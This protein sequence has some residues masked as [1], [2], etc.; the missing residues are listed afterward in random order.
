MNCFIFFD[1]CPR[2]RRI[3]IVIGTAES[4]LRKFLSGG[5]EIICSDTIKPAVRQVLCFWPRQSDVSTTAETARRGRENSV[6]T[7][8]EL[9][10]TT[11]CSD[12]SETN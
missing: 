7:A 6:A 2:R 5:E 10:V 9:F 1:T 8:S 12:I 11:K 4:G 3:P